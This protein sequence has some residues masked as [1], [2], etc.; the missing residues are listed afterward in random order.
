MNRLVQG[1]RRSAYKSGRTV[2]V[3]KGDII[4]HPKNE[5]A[6]RLIHLLGK[7]GFGQVWE[8][9]ILGIGRLNADRFKSYVGKHVAVKLS[10]KNTRDM[11][12]EFANLSKLSR[13]GVVRGVTMSIE[14]FSNPHDPERPWVVQ[15]ILGI[16][17]GNYL[18]QEGKLSIRGVLHMGLCLLNTI[19]Q[20]HKAGFVHQ[21][22][23]PDNIMLHSSKTRLD[24]CGDIYYIDFGGACDRDSRVSK[25]NPCRMVGTPH[26]MSIRQQTIGGKPI[27]RDDIET[28]V[29]T[30]IRC[31]SDRLPWMDYRYAHESRYSYYHRMVDQKKK[32]GPFDLASLFGPHAY[33]PFALMLLEGRSADADAPINYNLIRDAFM[34]AL[35]QTKK[36]AGTPGPRSVRSAIKG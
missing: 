13:R 2:Y 1:G 24:Q 20:V 12:A 21:D 15:E 31:I 28:I 33:V 34:V 19:Q 16:S 4:V 6:I 3:S 9:E 26:Y 18:R 22:I 17:L 8:G 27:F 35:R 5:S 14:E 7:G 10:L 11:I 23:K 36:G 30:C 29:Y 32:F 25:N